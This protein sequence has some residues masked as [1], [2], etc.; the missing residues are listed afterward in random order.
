MIKKVK[1]KEVDLH[2]ENVVLDELLSGWLVHT[3]KLVDSSLK[4]ILETFASRGNSLHDLKSVLLGDSWS[5]WVLSEVTS[6]SNTG[7]HDHSSL[8]LWEWWAVKTT[9]IH[10]RNMVVSWLQT[11]VVLDDLVEELVEG[12]VGVH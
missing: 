11:V 4:V 1:I 10:V 8:V 3:L 9:G 5:E 6:D 12:G 7:G 2:E